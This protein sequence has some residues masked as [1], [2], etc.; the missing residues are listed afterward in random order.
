MAIQKQ[1]F[2]ALDRLSPMQ[3]TVLAVSVWHIWEARNTAR[4]GDDHVQPTCVAMKILAYVDLIRQHCYDPDIQHRRDNICFPDRW[5]P[6]S[7]GTILIN[8]DAAVFPGLQKVGVGIVIRDH[9]GACLVACSQPLL[10][11]ATPE[12]AEAWALRSAVSL[13]SAEGFSSVIFASDCLSL[14]QRINSWCVDRSVVG[15]VVA[16]VK[17]LLEPFSSASFRHVKRTLNNSAHTLARSCERAVSCCIFHSVF[18]STV[19]S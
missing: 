13:A 3:A 7:P 16:D 1:W 15:A 18:G 2:D 19:G 10:G 6:P 4:N 8:F 12:L 14:V 5:S 17:L 11:T 9:R